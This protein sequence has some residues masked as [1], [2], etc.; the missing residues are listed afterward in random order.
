MTSLRLS[1][2]VLLVLLAAC[3]EGT[4][5]TSSGPVLPP[6]EDTVP[7]PETGL[8]FLRPA[9]NAPALGERQVQF[10]AVRGERRE[11]RLMYTKAPGAL[12]SVEF[13]RF[14]V[15]DR[16]LVTAA[17]GSPLASGDSV[18]ITLTIVDSLRLITQFEPAGL[19]FNPNRPAR[20]WLKYGEADPD[21]DD[22]GAVT[23]ADTALVQTLRV[24][25]QEQLGDPWYQ[26]PS[27][28]RLAE[29]EVEA[30]VPGFTR[31]AVAY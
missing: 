28:V 9:A 23:A 18:L 24:W 21:L 3:G 29:L 22:D 20:L 16:T 4:P 5:E 12:D 11:V 7:V 13:A 27:A 26:V 10:W 19:T 1:A 30:D 25:R 2:V 15:D 8:R 14:R 31:Y 17:D 6:V